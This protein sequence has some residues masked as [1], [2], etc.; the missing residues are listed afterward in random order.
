MI[1]VLSKLYN[2]SMNSPLISVIIP[3]Y[4]VE[5]FLRQCVDSV[6][7]QTYSNLEIILVDDG[8]LDNSGAICD[9]YATIDSRIKVIHKINGGL[10]AARN[11]GLDV[12]Q[13]EY[14]MFVDSD[15]IVHPRFVELLFN[16]IHNVDLVF[17][18]YSTFQE[19]EVPVF[20]EIESHPGLKMEGV[21]LLKNLRS[22]EYPASVI[23]WNKLYRAFLWNELRFPIGKIHED[24]FVVHH[25]LDKV[26]ELIFVS[27][28]L[29][30]YRQ[31]NSSLMS[32]VANSRKSLLNKM[33]AF[34]ERRNFFLARS[35]KPQINEMNSEIL[36]RCMTTAVRSNNLIWRS[37]GVK[38]IWIENQL[39][40]SARIILTFKK[41]CYPLYYILTVLNKKWKA[42]KFH[43]VI[44]NGDNKAL[45]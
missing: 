34:Y 26:H 19:T 1:R 43:D 17:C 23:S 44:D 33:E 29:Y 31:R 27:T 10:S 18:R 30:Y 35:M 25:L 16:Q 11:A 45:R 21:K 32:T 8:S 7:R 24:E 4:N 42:F 13:A 9:S 3:V 12:F 38:T 2:Q 37:I 40:I 14:V 5:S 41:V 39:P 28:P 22:F 36:Y 20:S 15:D 6:L